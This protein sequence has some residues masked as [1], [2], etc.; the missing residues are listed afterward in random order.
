MTTISDTPAQTPATSTTVVTVTY[1]KRWPLLRQALESARREG[2]GRAVVVDNGSH[3]DVEALVREAFGPDFCELVVM[4]RNTGSAAGFKS[5]IERAMASGSEFILLLDDDNVLEPGC[6][7]AL[8]GA[9]QAQARAMP[10]SGL[11]MLAYRADRMVDAATLGKPVGSAFTAFFGFRW[12][13]VPFKIYRRV[14]LVRKRLAQRPVQSE[15]V[16][17]IAPYSGMLFHRAVIEAH[18]VPDERFVLYADDTEFSYRLTRAG[19]KIMLVTEGRITDLEPS[20][21]TKSRHGSTFDALLCGGD[22]FRA[23]YSTRNNAYYE[24]WARDCGG[25]LSRRLNRMIFLG[26]LGAR[27]RM[28]GRQDRLRLL[29]HAMAEGEAGRLGIDAAFPLK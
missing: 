25:S 18:G 3:E 15:I 5:G 22:D 11:A 9:W 8:H 6:V 10:A 21:S 2:I 26:I 29:R 16:M 14:P 1:G 12:S 19:G 28:L 4:G 17:T 7:A 27:A 24:R 23:F 20:W 13:D